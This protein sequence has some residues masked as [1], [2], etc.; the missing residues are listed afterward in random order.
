MN[1]AAFGIIQASLAT[2]L[3]YRNISRLSQLSL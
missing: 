2:A 1:I 3:T